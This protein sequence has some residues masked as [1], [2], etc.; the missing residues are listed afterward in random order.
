MERGEQVGFLEKER[1]SFFRSYKHCYFERTSEK[2]NFLSC[3][4]RHFNPGDVLS[5]GHQDPNKIS[6]IR[7]WIQKY[8]GFSKNILILKN[9]LNHLCLG[10][11]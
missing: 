9:W 3:F 7:N 2:G 1:K 5:H 4:I 10:Q 6:R 8:L 11:N